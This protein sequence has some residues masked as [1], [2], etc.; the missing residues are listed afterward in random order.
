MKP[1]YTTNDLIALAYDFLDLLEESGGV[2]T[3]EIEAAL[4][5]LEGEVGDKLDALRWVSEVAKADAA[6]LKVEAKRLTQAAKARESLSESIKLRALGLLQAHTAL[7]GEPRLRTG[8]HTYWTA[9]TTSVQ[10]P[11]DPAA[12]PLPY[13]LEETTYKADKAGAKLALGAGQEI[14]GVALVEKTG[15]RWR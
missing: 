4:G 9:T 10:G 15:I 3:P 2:V 12:W 6:F 7:T 5:T 11:E 14:E 13:R 1:R 8:A